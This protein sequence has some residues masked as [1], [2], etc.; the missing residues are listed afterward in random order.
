MSF[1]RKFNR[2][3]RLFK[4]HFNLPKTIYFNFRVFGLKDALR[5]PVFLFGRIHLE[6]I[7][8]GCVEVLQIKTGSVR[9]GGGW[10]TELCGFSNRYKSFLR[11]NGKMILGGDNIMHQGIVV[12]VTKNATLRIGNNVYFNERVI[13]HSK[14]GITIG[15]NCRFGWNTQILDTGFHYMINKGKLAYRHAPVILEHNV[16]IAN[17]VS[18]MKGT[19]LPA[20]TVVASNSLVNKNFSQIGEHCLI[21]GVPAKYITDGVERLLIN[22]SEVDKLFGSPEEILEYDAVKNELEK[23][24]Y[25]KQ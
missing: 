4:L 23:T 16:W 20:Y 9:I 3:R 6:G 12:S 5:L 15:D 8:R 11:I 25:H 19:Y 22:E 17:S 21:G 18:I 2:L 7:H 10:F 1:L 13:I 14:Y 24:K